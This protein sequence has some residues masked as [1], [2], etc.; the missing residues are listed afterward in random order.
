M[1]GLQPNYGVR[2]HRAGN[3]AHEH[4]DDSYQDA[5]TE[6]DQ[7]IALRPGLAVVGEE[8]VSRE[9]GGRTEKRRLGLERGEKRDNDGANCEGAVNDEHDVGEHTLGLRCPLGLVPVPRPGR[10]AHSSTIRRRKY[11]CKSRMPAPRITITPTAF[12]SAKPRLALLL[13]VP[14]PN[15]VR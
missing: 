4:R 2:G 1:P 5:V 6:G 9:R 13:K 12:A 10:R 11:A 8:E 14:V 7:K 15:A 3:P